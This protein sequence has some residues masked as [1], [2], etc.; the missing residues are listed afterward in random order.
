MRS[1]VTG[2]SAA[3]A[4]LGF[5]WASGGYF[6]SEWGLATLA[7]LLLLVGT[8]FLAD[9]IEIGGRAVALLGA[10]AG[11]GAWQLSST[12]WSASA[13]APVLES[14]RTLLYLAAAAA[15]LL[16]VT[17]GTI[18]A[19]HEGIVAGATVVSIYALGTRLAPGTLGGAYDPSAGY[20]L[21]KPIGYWNALGLLVVF[22]LVLAAGAALRRQQVR[23]PIAAAAAVPLSVCLYFTF[24]RGSLIALAAAFVLLVAF[25]SNRT[26]AVLEVAAF[27]AAPAIG[28][29]LAARSAALTT[30]G[31]TLQTAQAQGHKLAIQLAVLAVL[32]AL[33]RVAVTR[34]LAWRQPD[35]LADRRVGLAVAV[36]VLGLGMVG[37]LQLGGPK[38]VADRAHAAFVSEPPAT[39]AGLDRRLLSA[40]GNGRSSYWRI[41]GEMVGRAPVL[42]EGAGAFARTWARDRPVPNEARDAHNLYLETLAELGAVGL[43]LVVALFAIPFSVLG[44]VREHPSAPAA[45]AGLAAFVVHAAIDWDWEIPLLTIIALACATSLLIVDPMRRSVRLSRRVRVAA[46]APLGIAIALALVGHVGNRAAADALDALAADKPEAAAAAAQRAQSWM[47]WSIEGDQ[48]LGE[49]LAEADRVPAAQ[50][51]LLR[52]SRKDPGEW[53]VWYDL[54]SVSTGRERAAA[55]TRARDLN[56]LSV[57]V[58]ALAA[59]IKEELP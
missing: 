31:A 45:A 38:A 17:P 2:A 56:P 35:R 57:E 22:G 11:L 33:G 10:L 18:S 53:S 8:F 50:A 34:A 47:R 32:A 54:A 27:C 55:I 44:R 4:V 41:A 30:A 37:V 46:L 23:A 13:A 48:L 43:L 3:A 52:A 40:S 59:D 49:A 6:P 58:S 36:A 29:M 15:L 39:T 28:V 26:T 25:A 14:E 12:L 42:G 51:V 9:R 20:Q 16:C 1:L 21:A 24:S 5:A 7:F 19:L